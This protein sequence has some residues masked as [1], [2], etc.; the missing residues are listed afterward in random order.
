M[1][2]KLFLLVSFLE[3]EASSNTAQL[4]VSSTSSNSCKRSDIHKVSQQDNTSQYI[5]IAIHMAK[6]AQ[7]L[8]R[9]LTSKLPVILNIRESP[10][11]V[12]TVE[13]EKSE[14]QNYTYSG[15]RCSIIGTEILR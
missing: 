8:T 9:G 13:Q 4:M 7:K 14:T 12:H 15:P 5:Q 10:R 11:G 3:M 6:I 2:E 1:Y